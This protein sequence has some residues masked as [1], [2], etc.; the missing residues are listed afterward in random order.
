M[1]SPPGKVLVAR[2]P[3]VRHCVRKNVCLNVRIYLL[4]NYS[5]KNIYLTYTNIPSISKFD[6]KHFIILFFLFGNN[7]T[8]HLFC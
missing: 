8:Q 7:R 3:I 5:G 1:N 4:V 2:R 6:L